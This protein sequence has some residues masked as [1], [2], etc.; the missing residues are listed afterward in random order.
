MRYMNRIQK[1]ISIVALPF[2]V[3][4]AFHCVRKA[5]VTESF[6]VKGHSMEPT[7]FNGETIWVN[8]LIV[9]PRF[10]F[11]NSD[12]ADT[13]K[14]VRLPGF[15]RLEVGDCAV[16]NC[17]YG[18]SQRK[19][20]FKKDKVYVKRCAACPGDTIEIFRG[21]LSNYRTGGIGLPYSSEQHLIAAADS[22][23]LEMKALKAGHFADMQ[24]S[25]TIK[26]FGPL[27]IPSKGM[28]VLI[29]PETLNVYRRVIEY[30]N[31][32][33]LS[34]AVLGETY[35]FE[36]DYYFFVGDNLVDSR[37]GR[38]DGFVPKKFIVGVVR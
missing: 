23:L 33:A 24:D 26:T 4:C 14:V 30:E 21:H 28:E 5:F 20:S 16:Y 11:S 22:S 36:E 6:V 18:D 27:V 8:K 3:V 37:D 13:K 1:V 2:L 34:P 9:G 10:V 35:R 25:W 7:F 17:Q 38:Y 15:G 19:I 29:T 32:E 12:V 31:Q